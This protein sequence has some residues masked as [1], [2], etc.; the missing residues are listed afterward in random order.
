MNF[1]LIYLRMP[2]TG[3]TSFSCLENIHSFGGKQ[4]GYWGNT[5]ISTRCSFDKKAINQIKNVI[6]AKR[7][8]NP[9]VFSTVRNPFERMVSMWKHKSFRN[10]KTFSEFCKLDQSSMG[11]MQRWH[12]QPIHFHLY[13]TDDSVN[14]VLRLETLQEDFDMMNNKLKLPCKKLPHK[15][16]SKHKHYTEYYDEE[17]KKIVAEKYAKD[18]EYFNYKFGE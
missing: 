8:K 7:Y 2:R 11:R 13:D 12:S 15:N 10:I 6:D 1:D 4:L 17:T 18:I 14:Y 3:S 9:I 16:K 5:N